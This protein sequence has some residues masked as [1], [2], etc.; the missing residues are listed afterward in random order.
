[1]DDGLALERRRARQR[2]VEDAA[3]T[4]EVGRR[5]GRL[6]HR[7]LGRHV[8]GGAE[9]CPG[10]RQVLALVVA[11]VP[12]VE[13]LRPRIPARPHDDIRRLEVA[14]DDALGV[15]G[16]QRVGHLMKQVAAVVCVL[17]EPGVPGPRT[18]AAAPAGEIR[19]LEELHREIR[20]IAG[21]ARVHT[22]VV[23]PHDM[24]VIDARDHP[25]L[26]REAGQCRLRH[27]DGLEQLE[28]L[29]RAVLAIA[30]TKHLAER[31]LA[32]GAHHLVA[33][34][35]ELVHPAAESSRAWRRAR[36]LEFGPSN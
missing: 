9:N 6:P 21:L 32:E 15:D 34:C 26:Q 14:V 23:D 27:P 13:Q 33:I 29:D 3:E 22:E 31:P 35:D 20:L 18:V 7:L 4:V 17:L 2:F 16:R 36:P 25:E 11:R 5:R 30:H 24:R 1:V 12:E 19:A 10:L 8:R 28:R